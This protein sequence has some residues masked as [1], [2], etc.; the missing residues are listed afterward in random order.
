MLMETTVCVSCDT[1][2]RKAFHKRFM[3]DK[4]STRHSNKSALDFTNTEVC[5]SYTTAP[6]TWWVIKLYGKA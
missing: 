1:I 5:F 3:N 6:A 2:D 4:A